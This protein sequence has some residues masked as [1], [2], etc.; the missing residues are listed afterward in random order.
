[1][2]EAALFDLAPDPWPAAVDGPTPVYLGWG[3]G[4]D[5]TC[6]LVRWILDPASRPPELVDDLGNLTVLVA[7]TGDEWAQ[8]IQVCEDWILPLLR[9]HSVRLVEVARAGPR[10]AD[11]I[12][13]LQDTRAPRRLHAVAAEHGFFGLSDEHRRNGVMPQLGGARR[14]SQ[15]AK[16][17]PLDRFRAEDSGTRPYVHAVGFH[18]GEGARIDKDESMTLG[19]QRTAIYPP[20][21]WGWDREDNAAYLAGIFRLPDGTPVRFGKS[22]CRQ[23]PFAGMNKAGWREQLARFLAHPAEAVPHLVDEFCTVA[24]N[25]RSGLFGPGDSLWRRLRRD[26]A[27]EVLAL[28]TAAIEAAPWGLYRVRRRFTAPARADRSTESVWVGSRAEVAETLRTVGEAT[29]LGVSTIDDH[30]RVVLRD[31]DPAAY[32]YL[33]EFYVGL[34]AQV[35]DKQVGAFDERWAVAVDGQLAEAE[36]AAA[37]VLMGLGGVRGTGQMAAPLV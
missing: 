13:V 3:M 26:G 5:S 20:H 6:A 11:G 29:G 8:T 9:Q 30:T 22:C 19:G 10:Q 31:R 25:P 23:C 21:E 17:W 32:P 33:E 15:K 36:R 1:M 35:D 14:C 28:A 16:G 18:A 27:E 37:V 24:L 2:S 12:V 4:V 7:Q 34:P